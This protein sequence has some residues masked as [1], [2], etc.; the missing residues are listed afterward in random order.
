ML[1]GCRFADPR[2]TRCLIRENGL[3]GITRI[4]FC[5]ELAQAACSL[6]GGGG[7]MDNGW[8]WCI[9]EC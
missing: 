8:E 6:G 5:G 1:L 3:I 9:G 2:H 7:W 4:I